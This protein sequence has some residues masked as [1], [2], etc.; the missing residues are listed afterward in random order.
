M[1]MPW[2]NGS[3]GEYR[4]GYQGSEMDNEVKGQGNSYTT[5]FRQLDPRVGRW[6]SIDP[7]ANAQ[8]SPYVSMSNNPIWFNDPYGDTIKVEGNLGF[9]IRV[10]ATLFIARLFSSDAKEKISD[11]K[12]SEN[13]HTIMK[14]TSGGNYSQSSSYGVDDSPEGLITT[15]TDRR[16]GT[17]TYTGTGEGTDSKIGWDIN[18]KDGGKDVTGNTKRPKR[19]GLLHEVF[20]SWQMDRGEIDR[21]MN[22]GLKQS[23]WD[24]THF[25]NQIRSQLR[26]VKS[27]E[28]RQY[29]GTIDILR[30]D[31]DYSRNKPIISHEPLIIALPKLPL[32]MGS[33]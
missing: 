18:S 30:R 32:I 15:Y 28:L 23:E 26:I 14:K 17:H 12:N 9:K 13:V 4:Y 20:H 1:Q 21:T 31:F 5:H 25:E 6:L 19:V 10:K 7:K 2:R 22:K 11:L 33:E 16:G 29:Y 8:E 27:I 24:A 3:T